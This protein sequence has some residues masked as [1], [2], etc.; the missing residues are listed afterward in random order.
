VETELVEDLFASR[1]GEGLRSDIPLGRLA[2]P[3]DIAGA[4][5][6]LASDASSYVTGS[7]IVIDGG[8]QLR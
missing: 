1:H 8:R 7:I 3:G 4:A 2:T 5:V 6:W